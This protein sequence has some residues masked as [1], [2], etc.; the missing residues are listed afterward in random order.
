MNIQ[1]MVFPQLLEHLIKIHRL[2]QGEITYD[3]INAAVAS[4]VLETIDHHCP[5]ADVLCKKD[6]V[7]FKQGQYL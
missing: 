5:P 1:I 7:A 6:P 2:A 3:V 4:F